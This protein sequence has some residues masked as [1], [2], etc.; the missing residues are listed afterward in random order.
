[1][2]TD[3]ERVLAVI[4]VCVES[5]SFGFFQTKRSQLPDLSGI[6]K[7]SQCQSSRN[8]TS[9]H[10]RADARQPTARTDRATLTLEICTHCH[11]AVASHGGQTHQR[12]T[13][14][15]PPTATPQ[16]DHVTSKRTPCRLRSHDRPPPS[17]NVLR[18]SARRHPQYS[19]RPR[20]RRLDEV[21]DAFMR[22][23]FGRLGRLGRSRAT[24]TPPPPVQ[25]VHHL[26][27]RLRFGQRYPRASR[28]RSV[29]EPLAALAPLYLS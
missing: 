29:D 19:H 8:P 15:G 28:A 1:M 9:T 17:W 14:S 11:A 4:I 6:S 27:G 22:G 25:P 24:A 16:P 18:C 23:R 20:D 2:T 12:S 21:D 3:T 7:A 26:G 5:V 10:A 13:R